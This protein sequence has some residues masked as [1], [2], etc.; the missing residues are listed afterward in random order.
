[1][2]EGRRNGKNKDRKRRTEMEMENGERGQGL[3]CISAASKLGVRVGT[4]V[5]GTEQ[6]EL[7]WL[8]QDGM[9]WDGMRRAGLG[10]WGGCCDLSH[11]PVEWA[12]HS[13]SYSLPPSSKW[14]TTL[15]D[16]HSAAPARASPCPSPGKTS[17]VE[18]IWHFP[19]PLRL[20]Q[21]SLGGP[22]G[23]VL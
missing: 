12:W 5:S 1:M 7:G 21:G 23:P 4:G 14:T 2:Q 13:A 10:S 17:R 18:Q 3:S 15:V 9:G 22:L 16:T 6:P 8:S 20:D 19:F 11:R